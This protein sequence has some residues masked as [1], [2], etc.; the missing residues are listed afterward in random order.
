[1]TLINKP[2]A[3]LRIAPTSNLNMKYCVYLRIATSVVIK[4]NETNNNA[5]SRKLLHLHEKDHNII[6]YIRMGNTI[7]KIY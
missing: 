6:I 3:I 4:E 1:M 2:I 5:K 7:I